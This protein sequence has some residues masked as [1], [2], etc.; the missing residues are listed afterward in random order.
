MV[1]IYAA[2]ESMYWD[3]MHCCTF[4]ILSRETWMQDQI[5]VTFVLT[6]MVGSNCISSSF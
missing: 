3:G 1:E 2:K 6:F 5:W 4:T